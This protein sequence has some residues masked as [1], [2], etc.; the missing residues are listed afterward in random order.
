MREWLVLLRKKKG[1]T[2]KE[3]AKKSAISQGYYSM[4]ENGER[5]QSIPL[6]TAQRIADVLEFPVEKFNNRCLGA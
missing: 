6:D 1:L 3:V 5:G 4:L 2:Q